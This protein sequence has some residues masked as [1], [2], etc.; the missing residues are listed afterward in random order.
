[1]EIVIV[2][3][4]VAILGLAA[5][6]AAGRFGQMQTE[7]VRDTFQPPVPEGALRASD[8]E[9]MRFGISPL[10]YDRSQVDDLVARMALQLNTRHHEKDPAMPPPR[11]TGTPQSPVDSDEDVSGWAKDSTE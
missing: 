10:G 3:I 6:V 5:L 4:A 11:E 1:M 9:R 8:L 7:P 2:V